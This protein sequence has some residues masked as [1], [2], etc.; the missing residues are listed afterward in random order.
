MSTVLD[1]PV[2]GAWADE[3]DERYEIID[4]VRV[5]LPPMSVDNAIL[6]GRLARRIS[7]FAEPAGVGEAHVEALVKLPLPVDRN[8]RPDLFFVP[9]ARWPRDKPIP[10]QNAW[11]VLPDLCAE[12]VSPNDLAEEVRDKVAEYLAAGVRVVWVFYPERGLA[13]VYEPAGVARHLTR[14]DTLDGGPVLPGFTL[15]LAELFPPPG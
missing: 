14:A 11:E 6:A 8:R 1:R 12:F 3:G 9:F 15:P 5:E 7:N 4:G 2:A 13:D 10:R